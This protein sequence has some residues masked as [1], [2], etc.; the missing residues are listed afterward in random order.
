LLGQWLAAPHITT[1]SYTTAITS[2]CIPWV[3]VTAIKLAFTDCCFDF[4]DYIEKWLVFVFVFF[5][6]LE[7]KRM[8][9]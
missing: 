5:L 6:F 2:L 7:E 9:S 8:K 4:I 1:V 3:L